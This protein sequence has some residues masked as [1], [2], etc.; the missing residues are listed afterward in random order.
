MHKAYRLLA[1][2]ILTGCSS[3][4]APGSGGGGGNPL[5]IP[6]AIFYV[7]LGTT[8]AN[9]SVAAFSTAPVAGGGTP[10]ALTGSPYNTTGSSSVGSPFGIAFKPGR[11]FLYA[12]NDTGTVSAFTV[13]ADGTLATLG[14]AVSTGGTGASGIAL[15]PAGTFAAAANSVNNTVQ[16]FSVAV[17]GTLAAVGSP[18]GTGGLNAPAAVAF[19]Q[20]GAHLYVSNNG[21]SGGVSGFNVSILG[22]LTAISGSPFASGGAATQGI[23]VSPNG[24]TVYAADQDTS[25]IAAL[26][27]AGDGS[28]SSQ[29]TVS[30]ATAPIGIALNA[31]GTILYVAAAASNAVDVFTVSGSSMSHLA[32]PYATQS[33]KTAMVSLDGSGKLLVALDELSFGATLFAVRPDGTLNG[34]PAPSYSIGT[35]SGHPA[36]VLAR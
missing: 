20:D 30:T 11:G 31:A 27:I 6:S 28:L 16:M 7:N 35:N 2:L 21:G 1:A 29:G 14:S 12:V 5:P 8:T 10:S 15:N 13:N 36:A 32:G 17:N 33:T 22:A 18:V 23:V 34:A 9:N 19:S 3:A 26:A 4:A 24:S 25:K